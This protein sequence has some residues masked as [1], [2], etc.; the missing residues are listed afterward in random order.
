MAVRTYFSSPNNLI[1]AITVTDM[2]AQITSKNFTK[3][4][5]LVK[6]GV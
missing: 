1:R 3:R 2:G 4:L 5:L 6:M